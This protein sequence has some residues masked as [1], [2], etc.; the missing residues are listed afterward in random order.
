MMIVQQFTPGR[1]NTWKRGDTGHKHM[2]WD[3]MDDEE[4]MQFSK[5]FIPLRMEKII[6]Y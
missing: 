1:L 3:D 6:I 5:L 4:S 2:R